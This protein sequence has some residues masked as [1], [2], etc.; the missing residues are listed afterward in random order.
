M[1]KKKKGVSFFPVFRN[2][3][4]HLITSIYQPM[5]AHIISHKTLL[6]QFKTL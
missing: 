4:K 3:I 6:K 2:E 1:E 5:N